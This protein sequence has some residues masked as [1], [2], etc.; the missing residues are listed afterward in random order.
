MAQTRAQVLDNIS[1]CGGMS[2]AEWIQFL[3]SIAFLT[4]LDGGSSLSASLRTVIQINDGNPIVIDWYADVIIPTTSTYFAKHGAFPLII[5]E[6]QDPDTLKWTPDAAPAYT[7][8][9]GRTILTLNPQT[10]NTNFIIL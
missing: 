7:W 1:P 5:E 6:N 2:Y 3:N 10:E 4:D 8:N 9:A